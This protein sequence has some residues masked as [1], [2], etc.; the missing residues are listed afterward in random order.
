MF[1]IAPTPEKLAQLPLNQIEKI[2]Y[3]SGFY[4]VKAKNIK[5]TANDLVKKFNSKV[6]DSMD[7]LMSL[8]GVGRKTAN[9]VRNLAFNLLGICV[10]IHVHR[11]SNRIGLIHTSKPIETEFELMKILPKKY[12]IIINELF[13]K[14][15]QNLCFPVSPKCSACPITDI[16]RKINV[17]KSR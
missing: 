14:F 17:K 8:P 2:I 9:L 4:K 3:P 6:P 7:E 16:C 13:V 10:D 11:I 15:G 5:T 12:W 1:S